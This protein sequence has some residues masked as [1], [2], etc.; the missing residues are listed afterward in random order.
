MHK[1]N[2]KQSHKN[3]I[4]LFVYVRLYVVKYITYVHIL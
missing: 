2:A 1:W 3:Y 4:I